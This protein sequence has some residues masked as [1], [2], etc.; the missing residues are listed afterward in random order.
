MSVTKTQKRSR[1]NESAIVKVHNP[2]LSIL[3][4]AHILPKYSIYLKAYGYFDIYKNFGL[5]AASFKDKDICQ[6]HLLYLISI[7]LCAQSYQMFLTSV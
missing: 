3:I 2:P 4:C 5:N 6:A 1:Y 7:N